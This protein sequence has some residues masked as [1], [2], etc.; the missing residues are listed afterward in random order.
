MCNRPINLKYRIHCNV[1]TTHVPYFLDITLAKEKKCHLVDIVFRTRRSVCFL[2]V[3][4]VS[5]IC[6]ELS[7]NAQ[8]Q[9]SHRTVQDRIICRK[10]SKESRILPWISTDISILCF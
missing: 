4:H 2:N 7:L 8:C 9:V 3:R 1:A 6:E 5:D 10:I